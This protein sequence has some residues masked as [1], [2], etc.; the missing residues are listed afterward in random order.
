MKVYSPPIL[1]GKPFEENT[2]LFAPD[3]S[4]GVHPEIRKQ[5]ELKHGCEEH[6]GDTV[7]TWIDL[8]LLISC[9]SKLRNFAMRA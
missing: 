3:K 4:R 6:P 9:P 5:R 8:S 7:G 2:E 1:A